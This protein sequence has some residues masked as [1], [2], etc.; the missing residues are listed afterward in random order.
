M[1]KISTYFSP[2]RFFRRIAGL[3]WG[4]K[5]SSCACMCVHVCV[6]VCMS[7]CV[8][9]MRVYVHASNVHTCTTKKKYTAKQTGKSPDTISYKKRGQ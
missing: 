2:A 8:C 3:L 9:V 1:S 5:S 7:V 6:R 4:S